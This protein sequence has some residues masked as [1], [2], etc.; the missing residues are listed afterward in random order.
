MNKKLCPIIIVGSGK[1]TLLHLNAYMKI[2]HDQEP[3]KIFIIAGD[4]I[5]IEIKDIL[6]KYPL[7]V[8]LKNLQQMVELRQPD[9]IIDICTPTATHR[10]IIEKMVDAGFGRFLVE[11][12]LVTTADDLEWIR[13]K[14]IHVA[15]M[16]NYMFS[17]ATQRALDLIQ[18]NEIEPKSMVSFFCKDR[19]QESI[20]R[21][22]FSGDEPPHVFTIELPHQLYIATEFLGPAK[23]V[24]AYA[25]N[26]Q[27]D[28]AVFSNH[29]TG[30]I[31][32]EHSRS[33]S[34][35]AQHS[36]SVHFSCLS[37]DKP[38]KCV[39]IS[40]NNGRTLTI[41]YPT[42]KNVLTS[43]IEIRDNIG[44]NRKEVFE[45]DDIMKRALEYYYTSL[46]SD[47]SD[48]ANSRYRPIDGAL[49]VIEALSKS[50]SIA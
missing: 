11:K 10:N 38:V 35:R 13:S 34:E 9:S 21:R 26:M 49:T 43:T 39:I 29:G 16:Q 33:F 45:N 22:G 47:V 23:V 14:N 40:D 2:W 1:A 41:H 27:T 36:T 46:T 4:V 15:I 3:P 12:P 6:K 7:F 28:D 24:A 30:V 5:D 50:N 19:M 48:Y 42:S 37:S 20:K 17:H 31:Y 18:E 25:K 32:L 8:Q 44:N